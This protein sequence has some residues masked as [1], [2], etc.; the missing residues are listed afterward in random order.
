LVGT[1]ADSGDQSG[2]DNVLGTDGRPLRPVLYITDVTFAPT[3]RTGD[4]QYHGTAYN[5]TAVYGTW[6]GATR[7]VTKTATT[8]TVTITPGTDAVK[9]NWTGLPD[10]PTG[11][12]S[13]LTNQGYGS[14]IV[15]TKAGLLAQGFTFA[16]GHNY[17]LQFMVHDGDQNK[18]GGDVGEACTTYHEPLLPPCIPPTQIASVNPSQHVISGQ[19]VVTEVQENNLSVFPNPASDKI[20]L[21]FI[22]LKTGAA[23]IWMTDISGKLLSDLYSGK[24]QAGQTNQ[25]TVNL[26]NYASGVYMIHFKTNDVIMTKKL[27]LSR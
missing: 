27:I 6:K 12:F 18:T 7:T 25:K 19:P 8:T 13:A 22:S 4:W 16:A 2:N 20:N 1:T 3:S 24:V 11:G 5:P 10:T 21:S 26:S 14:E 15:W 9:N 23:R 17:R